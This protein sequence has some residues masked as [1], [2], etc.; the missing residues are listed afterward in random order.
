M[1]IPFPETDN[2]LSWISWRNRTTEDNI[3]PSISMKVSRG[4]SRD[5]T[6]T[7]WSQSDMQ[8]TEPLR[9]EYLHRL[10]MASN[11]LRCFSIISI[12][13]EKRCMQK[14]NTS[15]WRL[16]NTNEYPKHKSSCRNKIYINTLQL[17]FPPTPTPHLHPQS[18]NV[19]PCSMKLRIL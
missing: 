16:G 1:H 4:P 5:Q 11:L 12:A 18:Q 17:H 14:N 3:S 2:C 19:L 15:S 7:S 13:P 6:A 10:I 8:P 9:P